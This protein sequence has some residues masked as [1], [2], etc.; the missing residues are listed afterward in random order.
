MSDKQVCRSFF[1]KFDKQT[2]LLIICD[3]Q[4]LLFITYGYF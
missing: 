4:M 2:Y 3:K 1:Y